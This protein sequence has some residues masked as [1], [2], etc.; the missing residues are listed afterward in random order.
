M[1][2]AAPASAWTDENGSDPGITLVQV[3]GWLGAI[4]LFALGVALSRR[5]RFLEDD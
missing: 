2:S 4:V 3:F 5:R 1:T